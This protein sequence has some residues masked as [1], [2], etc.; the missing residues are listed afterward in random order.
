[1]RSPR[2]DLIRWVFPVNMPLSTTNH[3][4]LDF[5][6]LQNYKPIS[7]FMISR[8]SIVIDLVFAGILMVIDW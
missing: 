1:M 3:E 6:L 7:W 8:S 5:V 2:L 4:L